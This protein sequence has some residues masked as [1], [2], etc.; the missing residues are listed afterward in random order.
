MSEKDPVVA[1]ALQALKRAFGARPEVQA[2]AAAAP[3]NSTGSP[4]LRA[5]FPP[6][7]LDAESK[8]GRPSARLFPFFNKTVHTPKGPGVLHQVLGERCRVA[9]DCDPKRMEEFFAEEVLPL[10]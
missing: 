8:F 2:S 1:E 5:P 9:L 6:E 3:S 10:M 7:S 4:K